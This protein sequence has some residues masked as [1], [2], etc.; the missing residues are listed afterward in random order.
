MNKH[1]NRKYALNEEIFSNIDTEEKAYWL[2][3]IAADANISSKRGVLTIV[4]SSEDEKHLS[5]FLSFVSS[6]KTIRYIWSKSP[7][8]DIYYKHARIDINSVQMI[9]DLERYGIGAKK[10]LTLLPPLID[11]KFYIPFIRGYFDGDGGI[12]THRV[13]KRKDMLQCAIVILST[14]EVCTWIKNILEDDGFSPK[15]TKRFKNDIN[16]WNV[17]INGN[18]NVMKFYEMYY[19]GKSLIL[20]RKLLTFEMIEKEFSKSHPV[21]QFCVYKRKGRSY[22]HY[23]FR[24]NGTIYQQGLFPIKQ[25]AFDCC[26]KKM[27]EIGNTTGL[28]KLIEM[29]KDCVV[30]S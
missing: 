12:S 5:K 2:G 4:L 16:I 14:L 18:Y 9:K 22:W 6:N 25:D 3:F 7:S 29:N 30:I 8:K 1:F 17:Q 10:S 15:I 19:K 20:D 21:K 11:K 28:K 26:Y 24:H 27:I 13:K 23:C